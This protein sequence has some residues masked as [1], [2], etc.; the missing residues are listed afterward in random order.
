MDKNLSLDNPVVEIISPYDVTYPITLL[1]NSM[2]TKLEQAQQAAEKLYY[3]VA[4]SSPAIAQIQ[5]ATQKGFRLVVDASESTLKG[6]QNGSIKLSTENAGKMYAQIREANGHYGEKLPIKEEY[7]SKGF[8]PVQVANALQMKA[9]QDQV[10]AI[11]EQINIIDHS[12]KAVL[13]GQQNDRIGLY[14]SGIAL[15]IEANNVTDE[16]MRNALIAQSLK[17]LTEASFQL[18]LTMQS[19]IQY[20]KNKEYK[21]IRGKSAKIIDERMSNI[22]KSFAFIHQAALM[23][24]G[25]YCSQGEL[26]AMST[27]LNEYSKF[28]GSVVTKNAELLSQCDTNDDGTENGVWK[29]RKKLQ[30]DVSELT[31]QLNSS[32]KTVYIG[33][34]EGVE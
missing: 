11:A 13:I 22:N 24:A 16:Y 12:V 31:K 3:A 25:I 28:I 26:G 33:L 32:E 15:F 7:F 19:D 8:D 10:Q 5:Q 30:L 9:L 29:T 4:E 2:N 18:T 23:R 21:S 17:S 34:L 27:V 6:I 1:S 14:Y 20:L